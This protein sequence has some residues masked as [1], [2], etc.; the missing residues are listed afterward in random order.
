MGNSALMRIGMQ[1]AAAL[2]LVIGLLSGCAAPEN[3]YE[4]ANPCNPCGAN[5]CNPCAGSEAKN[6]CNPCAANPCAGSAA[7]D[8]AGAINVDSQGVALGGYDPVSYFGGSPA[9]GVPAYTASH[10]GATYMFASA[11]NAAAFKAEPA[12]YAPAYGGYCAYA[13][14]KGST[15]PADPLSY[16]IQ[17]DTLL[18][19]FNDGTDTRALW[20]E[21]PAAFYADAEA[22][23]PSFGGG[24]P[25]PCAV[26]P[27]A[28]NPC[29]PNPCAPNPCAANPCAANPCAA[30]PCAPAAG[31]SGAKS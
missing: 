26:N 11:A 9:K 13:V 15:A 23:W 27:C 7:K 6:P 1:S 17:N 12:K 5:P 8:T 30:N 18:V 4:A 14:A 21:D 29:A 22:N 16:K 20:N 19:F 28:P 2:L 3:G 10:N 31:G 24:A 25:N